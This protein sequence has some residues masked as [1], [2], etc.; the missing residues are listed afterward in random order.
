MLGVNR[1]T[2]RRLFDR[3]GLPA[4]PRGP[5]RGVQMIVLAND[6]GRENPTLELVAKRRKR[7]A[8]RHVPATVQTLDV[9]HAALH[10]VPDD[11][12]NAFDDTLIDIAAAALLIH[13]HRQK[14]RRAA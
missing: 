10:A 13:D 8:D 2:V 3:L 12:P 11:E 5:R 1:K 9:A 4:Q 6:Q 14:L 7:W